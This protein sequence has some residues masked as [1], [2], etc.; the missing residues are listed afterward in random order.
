MNAKRRRVGSSSMRSAKR[1]LRTRG[2]GAVHQIQRFLADGDRPSNASTS[3]LRMPFR[4]RAVRNELGRDQF[5]PIN[6]DE[7]HARA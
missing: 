7:K 3:E 6:R 2:A 1:V 5:V 4:I